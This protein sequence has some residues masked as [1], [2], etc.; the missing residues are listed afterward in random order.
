M[1]IHVKDFDTPPE[2]SSEE[3]KR[4]FYLPNWANEFI[5][6]LRTPTNKTGFVVQ[7]GYFKAVGK[8]FVARKF[9]RADVEFVAGRLNCN[10]SDLNFGAYKERTLIRHQEVICENMGVNQFEE[11]AKE[12]LKKEAINLA[13]KQIKPRLMFMS[14][15]DF[16]RNRKIEVPSYNTFAEIITEALR[17][18]EKSLV[19]NINCRL[20]NEDKHLLDEL[21]EFG[22]EYV[23][24]EKKTSKVKRYK[25]TLLKKIN[26][27]T[28]PSK[29]KSNIQDLQCLEPLFELIKPVIKS[30]NISSDLILYYAQIVI[31]SRGFQINRRE[32]RKYLLLMAFVAYQ[33]YRLNDVLT[34]TLMKSVQS[35]INTT[36]REH[37]EN[38]YNQRKEKNKELY[39]F[40]K[41]MTSHLAVIEQAK[42]IIH[43]QTMS[44]N[45]K[46]ENLT[47]LFSK[48][49]DNASVEIRKQLS[50]MRKESGRITKNNDYYDI[51]ET[52]SLK[53]QNRVSEIIK[54]I[55]FDPK[56][57][58]RSLIQAIDHYKE[59]AGGVGSIAPVCFLSTE[60]QENL[61]NPDGK[62]R[63]S[64]YK[65]LLFE[66]ISDGIRSG[67]LNPIFST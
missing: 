27:S 41:K 21:L 58:N 56:T 40:S 6:T 28:K 18:F 54:N 50:G 2:F 12:S 43:S 19:N 48:D 53:L 24:G 20:T 15:V 46:I 17:N 45:E 29:I 66:K 55:K 5:E 11:N 31:K 23:G 39:I 63:V 16:L 34:E 13:S 61:F 4:F 62:F 51:L 26:Q 36:E 35:S 7:L 25:L 67:A 9:H 57:S 60:E 30:L 52:R 47:T 44:A 65:I 8:F 22:E 37:K 33:Y 14:L 3:R 10:C 1:K 49:F 42:A 38:F 59:K 32:S 64:L